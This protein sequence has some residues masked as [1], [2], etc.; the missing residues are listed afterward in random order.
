[1]A[2][3]KMTKTVGK[4][5]WSCGEWDSKSAA[6]KT[7]LDMIKALH[8][9]IVIKKGQGQHA[10]HMEALR[11]WMDGWFIAQVCIFT[12]LTKLVVIERNK[13]AKLRL[14]SGCQRKLKTLKRS[15]QVMER[16]CLSKSLH[17]KN[18]VTSSA[19]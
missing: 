13:N 12:T 9:E 7:V 19:S 14:R 6:M 18:K 16:D 1:M 2:F 11:W 3:C 15:K 5:T 8:T 10:G 17:T 4:E